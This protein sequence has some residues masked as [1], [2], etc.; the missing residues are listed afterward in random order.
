MI[1]LRI[2][3]PVF[4]DETWTKTYFTRWHCRARP[5]TGREDAIRSL[6]ILFLPRTANAGD[7]VVPDHLSSH[8]V[9]GVGQAI[10]AVGAQKAYL[11]PY[12]PDFKHLE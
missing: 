8:K 3:Q 12:S 5:A 10:E 11:P 7:I 6:A 4:L 9:A 1:G 2:D